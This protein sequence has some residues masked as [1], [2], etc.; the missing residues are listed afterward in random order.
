MLSSAVVVAILYHNI[1]SA[2]SLFSSSL[3]AVFE[4]SE[5]HRELSWPA[6]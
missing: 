5:N 4:L 3:S 2:S 6:G 1:F